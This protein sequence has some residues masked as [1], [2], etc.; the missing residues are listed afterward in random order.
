LYNEELNIHYYAQIVKLSKK[1]NKKNKQ[2]LNKDEG[3]GGVIPF[4]Y[5]DWSIH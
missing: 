5:D 1:K 3:R 2:K 4:E